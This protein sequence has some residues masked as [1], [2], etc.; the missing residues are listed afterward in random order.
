MKRFFERR[1]EAALAC[2]TLLWGSTFIVTKQLVRSGSPL[3]AF[4]Y[5]T[6]RFG[7]ATSILFAIFPGARRPSRALVRDALVLGFGQGMGLLF[8]VFGQ[9]Y[10]SASKSSFVTALATALTPLIALGLYRERPR[11]RQAAGAVL[12]TLGV[13][14]L[15]W[16]GADAEWNRGDL[17]SAA[18]ALI[19]AFVI[20]ETARRAPRHDVGVLT[21]LQ[22]ATC[23]MLFA[24]GLGL[25][26]LGLAIVPPDRLPDVFLLEAR[27]LHF[28]ARQIA[29]LLYMAIVCTVLSFLGQTWAMRR[30][31]ATHAA[32][33]FALEPV[34]ATGLAIAVEGGTEWPGA[35]GAFGALLV[36]G[37]LLVSELESTPRS[38]NDGAAG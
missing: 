8:Q 28:D 1:P 33:V 20:V 21:T 35:L 36:L 2:V 14:L 18:C 7:L 34:F 16:P 15:T 27:P 10:T 30:L 17:Y 6:M 13:L 37:G 19:Y 31:S 11:A 22:T 23:A 12:A 4:L 29:L 24:L 38:T 26:H 32:V 9:V 25:T 3:T 5:V